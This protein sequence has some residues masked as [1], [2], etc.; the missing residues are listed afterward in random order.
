VFTEKS[1]R[2]CGTLYT[3][4]EKGKTNMYKQ[5]ENLKMELKK[6]NW[7]AERMTQENS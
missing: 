2:K 6:W 4:K 5:E 7:L 3:E 1:K